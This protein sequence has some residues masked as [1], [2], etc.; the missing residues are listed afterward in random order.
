MLSF[1]VLLLLPLQ[2]VIDAANKERSLTKKT[3]IQKILAG[4]LLVLFTISFIPKSY[5]HDAFADH[6]D[7]AGCNYAIGKSACVHQQGFHC[8]FN[9]L[10][11]TAPYVA[12][13]S[14]FNLVQSFIHVS[15]TSKYH[16]PILPEYFFA[17][18]SRGPPSLIA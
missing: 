2:F 9:D 5:F 12:F 11:V 3:I 17:A 6:T 15:Y 1:L 8:S 7:S 16:I 10:V 18:E 4:L 13:S 14:G